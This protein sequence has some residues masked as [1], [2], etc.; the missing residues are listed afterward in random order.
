MNIDADD[1]AKTR[2]SSLAHRA[3]LL[4]VGPIVQ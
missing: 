2:L 1:L 4:S 3:G